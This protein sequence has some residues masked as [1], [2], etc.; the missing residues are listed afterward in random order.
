MRVGDGDI[1]SKNRAYHSFYIPKFKVGVS[2]NPLAYWPFVFLSKVCSF[3]F[4][5]NFADAPCFKDFFIIPYYCWLRDFYSGGHL[6]QSC[7]IRHHSDADFPSFCRV[8]LSL[9]GRG[10]RDFASEVLDWNRDLS[11]ELPH[12]LGHFETFGGL[13][14]FR[15]RGILFIAWADVW[16]KICIKRSPS[17]LL[18]CRIRISGPE[19]CIKTIWFISF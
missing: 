3:F 6:S 4:A 8:F 2:L 10:V 1:G 15:L 16:F 17:P 9:C 11:I 5:L 18:D 14:E 19:N 7:P 13:E 12:F